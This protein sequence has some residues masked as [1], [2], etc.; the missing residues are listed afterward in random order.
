M[1]GDRAEEDLQ[2]DAGADGEGHEEQKS[3]SKWIQITAQA[4]LLISLR[5]M[6]PTQ[7]C[8]YSISEQIVFHKNLRFFLL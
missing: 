6:V 3:Q 2:E 1:E 8:K 4:L 7:F 5:F